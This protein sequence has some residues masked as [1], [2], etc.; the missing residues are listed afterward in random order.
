MTRE[1]II[2]GTVGERPLPSAPTRN[3]PA[4]TRMLPLRPSASEI[5]PP[6]SAPMIAPNSSELT[7]APSVTEVSPRSSRM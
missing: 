5:F 4:R 6:S 1:A 3:N 7:T 2:N